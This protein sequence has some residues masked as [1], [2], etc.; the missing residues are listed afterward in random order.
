V[1]VSRTID[2]IEF[3]AG[4]WLYEQESQQVQPECLLLS[5]VPYRLM[6]LLKGRS[7]RVLRLEFPVLKRNLST[8]RT[9]RYSVA[10]V[11]GVPFSIIKHSIENQKHV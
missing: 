5:Y 11:G 4:Y 6:R 10:T 7:S 9:N 2:S 3:D 8:L 1:R